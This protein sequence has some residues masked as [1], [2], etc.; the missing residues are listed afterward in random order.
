MNLINIITSTFWTAIGFLF[1]KGAILITISLVSMFLSVSDF[2]K[3]N[4]FLMVLNAFAGVIGLSMNITANRY[5]AKKENIFS[6]FILLIIC[7][8]LGALIYL[9]LEIFYFKIFYFKLELLVSV[10]IIFSAI[11][12]NSL[13]GFF[14]AEAKFKKYA[15]VYTVQGLVIVFLSYF[16]GKK[17]NMQGVLIGMFLGYFFTVIYSFFYFL[18]Q[19]LKLEVSYILLRRSVKKV[20]FPNI[21]SGLLF[22]PAILITAFLIESYS[23]SSDVIA[24]TV[25]N[26]FRM[27]L[28]FLPITLGAVLLK[29]IIDNKSKKN[30]IMDRINY[31]LSYYPIMILSAILLFFNDII[32][33]LINNLDKNIFFLC[34]IIFV[35]A[36]IITSFKGAVA[37]KFVSEEKARISIFSNFSFFIIFIT[38]SLFIIPKYGAVGAAFS[39][40]ISQLVHVISWS[41]FYIKHNY[42]YLPFFDLKF[43]LSI[44]VYITLLISIYFNFQF[45]IISLFI[46]LLYLFY[47]E[48]K[49]LK[50][51]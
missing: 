28:G 43:F 20:F 50:I 44:P 10:F 8:L 15:Y 11:F 6:I 23:T 26:Q 4:L 42:Y 17:M 34:L 18:K 21:V 24:Y 37:R 19:K 47:N 39:F 13:S 25:A 51:K 14:Y 9:I 3:F 32:I 46:I 1:G 5:A 48:I 41:K 38:I 45:L 22:Q 2:T 35:A 33:V 12:S 7:S 36:S 29:L 49:L 40:L 16:L 30:P 27:V 31:S